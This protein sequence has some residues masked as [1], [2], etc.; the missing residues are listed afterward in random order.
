MQIERLSFRDFWYTRWGKRVLDLLLTVPILLALLPF[1]PILWL[2]VRWGVGKPVLIRQERVGYRGKRFTLYKLR[3]LRD[4]VQV[5]ERNKVRADDPRLTS[6]GRWLR[7][8][9][10]DE[11]PQLWNVL[12]G[13]MSLVGPRPLLPEDLPE[14]S[15]WPH[16]LRH[17]VR[18]GLTGWA[19]VNGRN[20]LNPERRDVLDSWYVQRLSPSLDLRI[21]LRTLL[22]LVRK[23]GVWHDETPSLRD[24]G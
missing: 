10:L 17:Q 4:G 16:M 5:E 14:E 7:A 3:T 2:L 13:E 11:L 22:E 19:Q 1:W 23:N 8:W 18:P 9:S 12:R 21:L 20:A 24:S 15:T 6:A